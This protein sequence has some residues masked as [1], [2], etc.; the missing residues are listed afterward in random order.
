MSLWNL[1]FLSNNS[2]NKAY[3]SF[4]RLEASSTASTSRLE[5]GQTKRIVRSVLTFMSLTTPLRSQ[6]DKTTLTFA[7]DDID[8][9]QMMAFV[10]TLSSTHVAFYYPNQTL[11]LRKS[12]IAVA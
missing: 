6:R 1:E 4:E 10:T 11:I 5:I 3:L 9:V 8:L 12:L 2:S 7:V